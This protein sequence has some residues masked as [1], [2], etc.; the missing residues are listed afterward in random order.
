MD[1]SS[2]TKHFTGTASKSR[3]TWLWGAALVVAAL[4]IFTTFFVSS[5]VQETIADG[6]VVID[7]DQGSA[8]EELLESPIPGVD[9]ETVGE[10][11]TTSD[12]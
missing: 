5:D 2:D 9:V 8:S 3:K 11:E 7:E 6:E 10:T 12:N 4:F 1:K